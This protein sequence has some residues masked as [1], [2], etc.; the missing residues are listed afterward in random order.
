MSILHS[1]VLFHKRMFFTAIHENIFLVHY[2]FIAFS[3]LT[4]N[5]QIFSLETHLKVL[6]LAIAM[7]TLVLLYQCH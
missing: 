2:K 7:K 5:M 4:D 3:H 1:D 6:P